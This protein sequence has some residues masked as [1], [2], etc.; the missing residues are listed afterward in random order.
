M[1]SSEHDALVLEYQH[2]RHRPQEDRALW[3]LKK[4][5]SLVKP[6]MRNHGWR[7]NTLCELYPSDRNL[8]G[9]NVRHGSSIRIH[10][11][12]RYASNQR[13]FLRLEAIT[14]TMLHE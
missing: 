7:I 6:V 12:L 10:L 4:V 14:D 9:L 13:S 8:L 3:L 5:A 1:R 11:R 2:D